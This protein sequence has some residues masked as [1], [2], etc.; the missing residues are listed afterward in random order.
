MIGALG[1]LARAGALAGGTERIPG[2]V[3]A[4]AVWAVCGRYKLRR[5]ARIAKPD[6]R[7]L[8]A[9]S[10]GHI[11]FSPRK[12]ESERVVG[13]EPSPEGRSE[14][15]PAFQGWAPMPEDSFSP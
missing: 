6:E 3:F 13:A 8:N 2:K 7:C 11:E 15:S 4:G 1:A 9:I 12:V 10:C 14:N 5:I